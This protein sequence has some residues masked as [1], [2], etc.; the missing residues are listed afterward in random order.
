MPDRLAGRVALVTGAGHGIGR[1]IAVLFAQ[2][3][4]RVVANVEKDEAEARS[5]EEEIGS[6]G[7]SVM[8]A[9]GDIS[10]EE[11]VRS[12]VR[13]AIERFGHLDILVNNAGIFPRSLMV[14]IS[15]EEWDRVL[16]VNLKGP[17][18]CCRAAAPH[19]IERRYGRIINISSGASIRGQPHG[20]H[21]G[22]SK[23]G[24]SGFT[25][26]IAYELAAHGITANSISPGVTDTAQPR[27]G[28]TEE[29]I[30][31]RGRQNPI[32]RIA[33]PIDIARAALFL[34][35]D[36]GGYVN[37]VNLLVNGGELMV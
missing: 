5:L 12:M 6:A 36:D 34:A 9:Y 23:A 11:T 17:F 14:D 25:R 35:S 8:I 4:A 22:A 26:S 3:G 28:M 2:E 19:M 10:D 32:R 29:E 16:D 31:E 15:D 18:R 7:G 20:A 27:F 1:A 21:Y 13:A 30:A 33:Q 24:L 37:G